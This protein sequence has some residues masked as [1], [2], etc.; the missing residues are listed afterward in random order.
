MSGDSDAA[1]RG[2]L[3]NDGDVFEQRLGVSV[4]VIASCSTS[5]QPRRFKCFR[6]VASFAVSPITRL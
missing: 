4:L 5:K 3:K 2:V 1:A 6:I